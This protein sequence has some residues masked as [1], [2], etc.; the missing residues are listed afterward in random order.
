MEDWWANKA[1]KASAKAAQSVV[2][3]AAKSSGQARADKARRTVATSVSMGATMIDC[4]LGTATRIA[5]PRF[6]PVYYAKGNIIG[7]SQV[8]ITPSPASVMPDI[9]C[10]KAAWQAI[11]KNL[12][13]SILEEPEE[14]LSDSGSKYVLTPRY[15]SLKTEHEINSRRKKTSKPKFVQP[16]F[17]GHVEVCTAIQKA[18][19]RLEAEWLS[20]GIWPGLMPDCWGKVTSLAVTKH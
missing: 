4:E 9:P 2:K 16:R 13:T 8:L 20:S 18:S 10:G 12:G 11:C 14:R 15:N 17:W 5:S 3:V 19:R 7:I 1:N 6:L